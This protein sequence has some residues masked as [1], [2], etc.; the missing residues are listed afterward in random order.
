MKVFIS[1]G[2]RDM[3][4][5]KQIGRCIND[6]GAQIFLDAYDLATGDDIE[7]RIWANLKGCD[8]LLA[9]F[10]PQSDRRGWV[11]MEIGA[12][13]AMSKRVAA[14]LYG[15]TVADLEREHGAGPILR[16]LARDLNEIDLY[17]DE[18]RARCVNER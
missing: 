2:A 3:W 18:L 17:F 10:T 6:V 13:R 12:A 14:V 7:S 5:A 9:L 16:L 15:V 4:I 11:W 8:E 1:H